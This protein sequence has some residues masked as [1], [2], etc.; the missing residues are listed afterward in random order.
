M[1][2][3]IVNICYTLFFLAAIMFETFCLLEYRA[4][5][6]A[7]IGG[8]II[9]LIASFLFIDMIVIL[10][11]KERERF[12]KESRDREERQAKLVKDELEEILKYQKVTYLVVKKSLQASNR[13]IEKDR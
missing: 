12:F 8:G 10:Y 3:R 2:G 5:A 9:V 1:K 6:V 7:V 11:V 13:D 4:D